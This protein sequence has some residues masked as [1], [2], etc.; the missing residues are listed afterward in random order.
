MLFSMPMANKFFK[1]LMYNEI[2]IKTGTSH[3]SSSHSHI[4]VA[5]KTKERELKKTSLSIKEFIDR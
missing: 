4:F 2:T 1:C 3:S 5:H